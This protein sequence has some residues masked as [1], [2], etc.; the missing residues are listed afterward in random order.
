MA[1]RHPVVRR[2][3]VT[4]GSGRRLLRRGRW[5]SHGDGVDRVDSSSVATR[6]RLG[7]RS[8]GTPI[9]RNSSQA[10]TPLSS[11]TYPE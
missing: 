6:M 7:D 11:L 4:S 1:G 9:E 10:E 8:S 5:S 3:M 2:R